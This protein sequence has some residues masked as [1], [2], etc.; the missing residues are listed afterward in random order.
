M[1]RSS[2]AALESKSHYTAAPAGAAVPRPLPVCVALAIAAF[3][4]VDPLG[5]GTSALG[6]SEM[7]RFIEQQRLRPM[8]E[9]LLAYTAQATASN[10]AAQPT[11]ADRA[12]N[13]NPGEGMPHELLGAPVLVTGSFDQL[14][15][16][17]F[18]STL[19]AAR[20]D[21]GEVRALADEMGRRTTE[22]RQR[23]GSP[24]PVSVQLRAA[25][26]TH[27]P[28]KSELPAIAQISE[29]S[30]SAA[31][32]TAARLNEAP[33]PAP[34]KRAAQPLEIRAEPSAPPSRP[35]APPL[36][37]LMSLGGAN[38]VTASVDPAAV[39]DGAGP[40]G[41][42]VTIT[43]EPR[44][45]DAAEAPPSAGSSP[46]AAQPASEPVSPAARPAPTVERPRV[47]GKPMSA[48]AA[49]G[50]VPLSP[51]K[52][53][54]RNRTAPQPATLSE[55]PALPSSKSAKSGRGKPVQ[56]SA[57][58]PPAPEV[59]TSNTAAQAGQATSNTA[60]TNAAGAGEEDKEKKGLFSWFKPLG[61][62]IEMPREIRSHGWAND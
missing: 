61:K 19:N 9:A 35:P 11:F 1:Y 60:Q 29:P 5:G 38:K 55:P 18:Q 31:D 52:D 36:P 62:P 23:L 33:K 7:P 22:I 25:A 26:G 32:T 58:L 24:D 59:K 44:Q 53:R 56:K 4:I 34:G 46:A 6:A 8:Q 47:T 3:A 39:P 43:A 21:A 37:G 45:K 20:K 13:R 28:N 16:S 48:A 41:V 15:T 30:A 57:S 12:P 40:P 14:T 42:G 49:Y 10:I 27:L 51:P 2:F 50:F 17:E 54:T